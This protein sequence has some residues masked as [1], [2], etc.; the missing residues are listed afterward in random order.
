MSLEYFRYL[1]SCIRFDDKIDRVERRERDKLAAIRNVF[2]KQNDN[3]K[4]LYVVGDCVTVDEQLI[5]FRGKS[6]FTQYI[7]SKPYKYGIKVW[8]LCDSRTY[9]AYNMQVYTGKGRNCAPEKN[10]GKRFVLD[11]TH[12]LSGRNVTCDN[13]FTSHALAKELQNR[14][15]T[16]VGTMR[17][18]RTEI[19]PIILDM[20]KK[21]NYHSEF[22][23]DHKLRATMVSYVPKQNKYV[24]LLSTLH[25]KKSVHHDT[26]EKKP[27]IIHYYNETKSGVDV[28]D[29]RVGTYRCKRKVNRWP[30]AIFENMLCL[31]SMH[32]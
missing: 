13:F 2:Q 18:N 28:L 10:Q 17:K 23:F 15:M 27:D 7:P 6:P 3:L 30:M 11:L 5:P 21:P 14:K 31:C 8:A 4:T 29:E 22:V 20:K 32:S 24:V 12:G 9:Y 19:P 16:L 26:E 25:T 1:N